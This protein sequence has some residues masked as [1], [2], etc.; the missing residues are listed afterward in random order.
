MHICFAPKKRFSHIS[1]RNIIS[2][3][4]LFNL[5]SATIYRPMAPLKVKDGVHKRKYITSTPAFRLHNFVKLFVAESSSQKSSKAVINGNT[6]ENDVLNVCRRVRFINS[7]IALTTETMTAGSSAGIDV[8]IDHNSIKVGI[9]CKRKFAA[10]MQLSLQYDAENNLWRSGGKNK[11]PH[12]A[13][14]LFEQGICDAKIFNNKV[15][16]FVNNNIT[17]EEWTRTKKN[18]N[19]QRIPCSSDLISKMYYAKGCSYIQVGTHGLYHTYKD[20]CNFGVAYFECE[21]A[22]RIRTKIHSRKNKRGY[23]IASVTASVVPKICR[24]K[25]SNFSLDSL[26]NL[27]KNVTLVKN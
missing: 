14:N 13:K 6:Y 7:P 8:I 22:I 15:P 1:R 17:H 11:I 23:M 2:S 26:D 21:S 16:A 25:R 12:A 10:G 9:E 4:P 18:F 19:D 27:P 5:D 24:I 3:I 20:V